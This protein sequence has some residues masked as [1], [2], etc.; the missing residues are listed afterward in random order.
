MDCSL[1]G[2]FVPG[3]LQ[4][5]IL[6]N[7]GLPFPSPGDLP[8]PGIESW[9]PTLQADCVPIELPGKPIGVILKIL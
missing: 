1:P 5:G 7:T 9:S 6:E 3:I 8:N 2:F 4:A